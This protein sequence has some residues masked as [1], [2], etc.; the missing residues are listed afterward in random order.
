[1]SAYHPPID[2]LTF[3]LTQVVGLSDVLTTLGSDVESSDIAAALAEAGRLAADVIAPLNTVGDRTPPR[4]ENGQVVTPPGWA[5]AYQRFVDGGWNGIAGKPE[6]GGMGLPALA[7][8]AVQELWHGANMAFALCPMLTQAGI[9]LIGHHG[10]DAQRQRYLEPLTTG[11]WTG[12]MLLTEPNA[13]SDVGQLR[14]RAVREGDHY[15]LFGQKI[16]ITY[17]DHDMT[18]NIIHLILARVEGAPAGIKGI[19]LFVAPKVLVNDDGSLGARND[20]RPVSLEHKLGIHAS[21]TCVMAFGDEEGAYAELIGEENRGIEYMFLMMN[22]ARLNVG[23]QGVGIAERAYQQALGYAQTRVQGRVVG[24]SGADLAIIHHPDVARMLA[25][26]KAKIGAARALY[27]EAAALLDR[28][29]AGDP[30]A[31]MRADLLIP[32]VKAW[33]TDL[34]CEVASTGIQVHGG[35]GFIEDTGAA[36]H[37]RD[38]RIAPIYEGTNGI[39]ANDLMLRKIGRDGG[40]T[41]RQLLEAIVAV[42]GQLM[43][44]PGDDLPAI[45]T[46]LAAAARALGQATDWVVATLDDDQRLALAGA[47]PL[48]ELTGI[49]AGG[50]MAARAAL[51]AAQAQSQRMGDP[52]YLDA[53]IVL[54][55]VYADHV[56]AAA[57]GLARRVTE[58]GRS[59]VSIDPS[60]L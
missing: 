50:W 5:A 55:R 39:Q 4:L 24:R 59:I 47:V 40:R 35:M 12:T 21:P 15:R 60:I 31:L 53:K 52:T 51:A 22:S 29:G 37:Y 27:L 26:S 58:G 23:I 1:M 25:V 20:C 32:V 10:S 36:Q 38:A 9:D 16:Y 17:G 42:A 13:G 56:L 54:G 33:S 3:L 48:L 11:A 30:A 28:G 7:S 49:V 46:N 44:Q 6:F 8:A 18:P 14:T 45:G 57:D 43:E 41:M 19:S 2:D 34:G